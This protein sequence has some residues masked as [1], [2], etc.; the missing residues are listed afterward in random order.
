MLKSRFLWKLYAGYSA[1]IIISAIVVG[2]LISRSIEQDTLEEI[3][4]SL[5][6]RAT[7]L[8]KRSIEYFQK[9]DSAFQEHIRALGAEIGTR[10]TVIRVDGF[11]V[12]D[13]EEDPADMD[14]HA[15]RPE[16]LAA[17]ANGIGTSTRFSD[18]LKV[19]M[20]YLAIPL[21]D[22]DKIMGYVR[23]SLPLS[24]I[25]K[26]LDAI[27]DSVVWGAVL[28]SVAALVLGFFVAH[29]FI[30]P[31]SSM[32]IVAGAMS[33]GDYDQRLPMSRNDEIGTLAKA[34]NVL[35]ESC[36]DR[37]ETII[38][39]RNRLSAILSGMNE[40]VIAVEKDERVS[41]MNQAAGRILDVS[42][43]DCLGRP[44]WEVVR[45]QDISEILGAVLNGPADSQDDLR[46]DAQLKKGR[47]IEVHA[48]PLLDGQGELV[49]AVVV[50]HDVS[51]FKK[52]AMVRR[53]FVANASHELKTPITAI[54]GI[55]ETLI[56]DKE[57][58][59]DKSERFLCKIK[60]QS[61]RLSAIVSD[62]LTLSRLESKG[63]ETEGGPLDLRQIVLSSVRAFR[64]IGAEHGL[65]IDTDILDTPLNIMGDAAAF[66]QMMSNLLD[67]AV[68]YTPE[69]G[70]VEVRLNSRG[71]Q[72]IIEVQ[73]TGIGIDSQDQA[74]I[75]ERF[76]RVDKA[77]SRELGG[78]GLGLSIVKHIAITHR[79]GVTVD[80]TP[81][82]GS[83]FRVTLP[84]LADTRNAGS[85]E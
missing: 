72:I 44:I 21:R 48:S 12:A 23:T 41:H 11:V 25:G 5:Q 61:M 52:L 40:G 71:D 58:D 79:G 29:H 59:P 31:L 76:Y 68:K 66:R 3:G 2:V 51:E 43:D 7:I 14:N 65:V 82:V 22:Q 73:D 26:R 46:I 38:T 50:I 36:R 13:S 8:K 62:L 84:K 28:S 67:N 17:R 70:R 75:F 64:Q 4:Q 74:R 27:R 45:V 47:F 15:D 78:T 33:Q 6:A 83:T 56:D 49:G 39:D 34:F 42:A 81:G 9:P 19:R 57:L 18:T 24:R 30:K 16:V 37:T 20:M 35:A 63:D 32:T 55:V 54:R 69:G 53:E 10:L 80:S 60:D 1:L 77:R 85:P